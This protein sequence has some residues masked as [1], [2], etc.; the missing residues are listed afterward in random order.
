MIIRICSDLALKENKK[1]KRSGGNQ[2]PYVWPYVITRNIWRPD[3]WLHCAPKCLSASRAC[4][5]S[6][7]ILYINTTRRREESKWWVF[8]RFDPRLWSS[9]KHTKCI[10][11]VPQGIDIDHRRGHKAKRTAPKSKDVYLLLLVKVRI[12]PPCDLG[13]SSAILIRTCHY[14]HS[15]CR[16]LS[17]VP[18]FGPS[19]S[20][21]F[22]QGRVETFVH[23]SHQ[24]SSNI[25]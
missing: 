8:I 7:L 4:R 11:L 17:V 1:I 12:T 10:Y 13:R 5:V 2:C 3:R 22:Q 23:V 18:L 25:A 16:A 6:L 24:P 19:Y 20:V 9:Y 21:P 15:K 14:T